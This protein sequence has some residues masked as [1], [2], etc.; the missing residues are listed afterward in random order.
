M[1][2]IYPSIL[3][4]YSENELEKHVKYLNGF[5]SGENNPGFLGESELDEEIIKLCRGLGLSQIEESL[6]NKFPYI[7]KQDKGK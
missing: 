3:K 7:K 6:E 2:I 4:E 5:G 1:N